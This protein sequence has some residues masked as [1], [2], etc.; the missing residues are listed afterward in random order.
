MPNRIAV[1][2]GTFDPVTL[3]HLDIIKRAAAIVDRLIIGVAKD[4]GKD[5]LFSLDERVALTSAEVKN[6]G[7][8]CPIEV[9]PFSGLLV[10]FAEK[11]A[12]GLIIRGMRAVSDFEYEFKM[13]VMNRR[14]NKQIDTVYLMASESNQFVSS[15][16]VKEI[17]RLNG[18]I[19]S[20]VTADTEKA[21]RNKF[22]S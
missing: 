20:F 6:L 14:L 13:C 18:D 19:S 11:N 5:S 16:F 7:L 10:D 12:A 15:R 17:C 21:L 3:G 4:T 9:M 1:Y 2:P 22:F 8:T